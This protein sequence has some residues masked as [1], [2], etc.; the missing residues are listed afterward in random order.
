MIN[1]VIVIDKSQEMT[2]FD[3]VAILRRTLHIKKIGHTGTLDPM[4]TGVLP[5]CIGDATKLV[6]HLMDKEKHY[7][8]EMVLGK[9]TST[10]DAWGEVIEE[11]EVP[12]LTDDV[13]HQTIKRFEGEIMQVPPMYSAIKIK[14][15]KLVDLA[16]KGIE[17]ERQPRPVTI[18]AIE[19]IVIKDI[20]I[21]FDVKCSK[22]TYIRTLCD[23][24]GRALG[25]VAHMTAL[26]R[27]ASKPFDLSMALPISNLTEENILENL[28]SIE[29]A[30]SNF[31]ELSVEANAAILKKINN[32]VK[33]NLLR[34]QDDKKSFIKPEDLIKGQL[35]RLYVN[36]VFY[37]IAD[38]RNQG[39][40]LKRRFDKVLKQCDKQES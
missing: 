9:A 30:L 19:N 38:E 36:G 20:K 28:I 37:G 22:G 4:A 10:L 7:A 6:D 40:Y 35:Y 18:Y 39:I 8:C 27:M 25:T 13:I 12:N 16:R 24:I 21:A 34:Y 26:R 3:V 11:K 31:P 17:V 33:L 2:S 23:D 32:G 1:G 29:E 14:G 15:Q 5:I